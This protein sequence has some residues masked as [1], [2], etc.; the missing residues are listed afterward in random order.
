MLM[1][2]VVWN[3][4]INPYP[5]SC[6]VVEIDLQILYMMMILIVSV[7]KIS[8]PNPAIELALLLRI[9]MFTIHPNEK[10]LFSNNFR[11]QQQLDLF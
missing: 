2:M 3:E 1:I 10:N 5:N 8:A 6:S 7:A 11:L 4:L 9:K